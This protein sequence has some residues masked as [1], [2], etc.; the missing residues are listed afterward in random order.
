[1]KKGIHPE[2]HQAKARCSC[3]HEFVVGSTMKELRLDICSACHPFFTGKQKF[4][5]TAGRIDKYFRKYGKDAQRTS[6]KSKR[7]RLSDEEVDALGLDDERDQA[8]DASA[9]E[10]SAAP[11]ADDATTEEPAKEETSIQEDKSDS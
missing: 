3:G 9:T 6:S 5:D 4:V 8:E 2:Y 11:N 1:M 10:A 7:K